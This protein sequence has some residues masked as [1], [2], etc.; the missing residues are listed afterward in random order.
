MKVPEHI[1]KEIWLGR[2]DLPESERTPRCVV[3]SRNYGSS[4]AKF[5]DFAA[6]ARK[7]YPQLS[8]D[9]IEIVHYGGDRIARTFGIE[10][11]PP[12][13]KPVLEGWT[14]IHQLELTK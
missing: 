6:E 12:V 8:D 10:F 9:D 1:I 5:L 14:I 11:V 2:E 7:D 3:R 4:L 13:K